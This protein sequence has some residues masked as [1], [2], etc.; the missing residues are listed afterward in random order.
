MVSFPGRTCAK[1]FRF[2]GEK[3][4]VKKLK[5]SPTLLGYREHKEGTSIL[6]PDTVRWTKAS[7]W[8]RPSLFQAF[9]RHTEGFK[10]VGAG[11]WQG[12]PWWLGRVRREG[13]RK[14]GKTDCFLALSFCYYEYRGKTNR[15]PHQEPPYPRTLSPW[16]NSTCV[17]VILGDKGLTITPF[18]LQYPLFSSFC[19][20]MMPVL[21][22]DSSFIHFQ[23]VNTF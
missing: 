23:L 2:K 20:L 4:K 6:L 13:G 11:L 19:W 18:I 14:R 15:L 16:Y 9:R 1:V 22:C 17:G 3:G 7:L 21:I 10:E 8:W 5:K 12:E